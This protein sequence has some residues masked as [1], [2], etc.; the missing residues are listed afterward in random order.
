MEPELLIIEVKKLEG[1]RCIDTQTGEPHTITNVR[2]ESKP[3][4]E[5]AGAQAGNL[6]TFKRILFDALYDK[7]WARDGR[8]ALTRDLA[9]LTEDSLL[10]E[11]PNPNE[12]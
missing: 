2:V 6:I 4:S 11:Q 9:Y 1:L 5:V 8:R 3:L 10:A 12:R 7:P